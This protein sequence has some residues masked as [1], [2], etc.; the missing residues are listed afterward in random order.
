M[1]T[2]SGNGNSK[3]G[4]DN[5]QRRATRTV[6]QIIN[7][8]GRKEREEERQINQNIQIKPLFPTSTS[9]KMSKIDQQRRANALTF[10]LRYYGQQWSTSLILN[11]NDEY[12]NQVVQNFQNVG[13]DPKLLFHI[14]KLQGENNFAVSLGSGT[15]GIARA[16]KRRK[17]IELAMVQ[18]Q[19]IFH[20]ADVEQ[21]STSGHSTPPVFHTHTIQ[22]P[23]SLKSCPS[24]RPFCDS[25]IYCPRNQAILIP[26]QTDRAHTRPHLHATV[27]IAQ[28]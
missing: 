1:S 18:R 25:G 7:K 14:E 3:L 22:T 19:E 11:Q 13:Y 16:T 9:G 4:P 10:G 28:T 12:I 21:V 24:A 17:L 8:A 27:D 23:L 2:Y 6:L 15:P 26:V 5:A 20:D